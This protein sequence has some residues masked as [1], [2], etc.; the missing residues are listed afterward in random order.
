[1][2]KN[3]SYFEGAQIILHVPPEK[4]HL[5][6]HMPEKGTILWHKQKSNR[7]KVMVILTC[8]AQIK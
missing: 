3:I 8:T 5:E 1:M 2:F 6:I 7:N 4:K